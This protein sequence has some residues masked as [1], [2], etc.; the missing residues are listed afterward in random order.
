MITHDLNHDALGTKILNLIKELYPICRSITGEGVRKTLNIIKKHVPLE[1]IEVPSGTKV[2]DWIVP[3]EWN[4][5]D[6]YIKNSRGQKIVDFSM[7][8]LHV[9]NYSIPI[10]GKFKF[11][12]L[13]DHV[14][15]IPEHPTWIPYRTSYYKEDW[16]FCMPHVKFQ[17]LQ[18]DDD[19]FEILIDSSLKDGYL[20][21]GEYY[22]SGRSE[23]EFLFSTYI[24]H[25]SLCNDNLTGPA[26]QTFLA[27]K[28][29]EISEQGKLKNSYRFLWIP[30]TIG[31]ITWLSR[32]EK[33][34]QRI[35]YGLVLTC[36]G[37]SG[38]FTYKKSRKG[39]ALIDKI[40][41][42][43]LKESNTSYKIIDFYPF[44]SDERQYCSPGFNLPVGSLMRTPYGNYQEYHTSADNLNFIKVENLIESYEK[45]LKIIEIAEKNKIYLNT[46][47]KCEPQLSK[48]S[49]YE[50]IGGENKR[51]I[52]KE[53]ILWVL[54][55]SDG[56]HS[57]LDISI[58]SNLRFSDILNATRILEEKGLLQEIK[59]N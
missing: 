46:N 57:L 10:K 19:E 2:F 20:T 55:L 13:K 31:A 37:D 14:Y 47:P 38:Q 39:N 29:K 56:N 34:V 3:K 11:S 16:G 5:K 40:V 23:S 51:K 8:N 32:N 45:Y 6:A 1:I 15:T 12:E 42:K 21:Y 43:V 18:D 33:K 9:L 36:L 35:K 28:I 58:R 53:A 25:P 17:E 7:S 24:C 49:L 52:D 48:Y 26:I 4:I 54:N 50:T 27:K 22:I 30:E 44:G 59:I 41:E